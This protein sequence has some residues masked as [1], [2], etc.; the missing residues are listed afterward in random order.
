MQNNDLEKMRD[1]GE[2]ELE[3]EQESAAAMDAEVMHGDTPEPPQAAET[4][5]GQPT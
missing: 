5:E 2:N 4:T 1:D 3:A